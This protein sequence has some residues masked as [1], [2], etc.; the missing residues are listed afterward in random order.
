MII[1]GAGLAGLLA[2]NILRKYHPK[3]Y[4]AQN[5]LPNNHSALLRFRTS[6]VGTACSIPFKR[7]KVSK[8]IKGDE[9]II[10]QPNLFYSNM[11]SQKVTNSVLSRS[12]RS[13]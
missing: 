1:F 10:S 12:Y 2:G 3:I 11:Y 13:V 7:V 5:E 8:A 9:G 4:E 6:D